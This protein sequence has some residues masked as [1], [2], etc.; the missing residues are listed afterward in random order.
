MDEHF[1]RPRRGRQFQAELM[2]EVEH[3]T[4]RQL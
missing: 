3:S 4:G 2:G 1:D